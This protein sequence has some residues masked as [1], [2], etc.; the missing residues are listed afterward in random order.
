MK[1]EA[2]LNLIRRFWP[3]VVVAGAIFVSS[4]TVISSKQW[5]KMASSFWPGGMTEEG[6]ALFW[7]HWWWLFVKG[8]H[9]TV[10]ALLSLVCRHCLK[11]R[12]DWWAVLLTVLLA[13]GDEVHQLWVP[14]RGGLISDWLIDCLGILLAWRIAT[15]AARLKEDGQLSKLWYEAMWLP[16]VVP[17]LWLLAVKPF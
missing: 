10:F 1:N 7:L 4:S 5:V 16:G 11:P 2:A 14:R 3:L 15:R 8:W 9:A 6:F 13:A 12:P 17:L